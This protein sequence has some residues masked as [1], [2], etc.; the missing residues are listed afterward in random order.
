[1]KKPN[2]STEALQPYIEQIEKLPKVQRLVIC[3]GTIAVIL[4]LFI[5][6]SAWPKYDKINK[7]STEIEKL[8]K[9]LASMKIEAAK[10]P[11]YRKKLEDSKAEFALVKKKLPEEKDIP[12]LLNS[13]S[14]SGKEAGLELLLFQLEKEVQKD[15]YA[16][17]P[18]SIKI[19]GGYHN[20]GQFLSKVA[21]LSRVVNIR[22]LVLRPDKG[23]S[24]LTTS[25]TAVTYRFVDKPAAKK[26]SKKS[27]KR[28]KK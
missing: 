10:L 18:V 15:F 8:D 19:H 27:K 6:L 11:Q 5:Y 13:I 21:S 24:I 28:K 4:G 22:N 12:D 26:A 2:I 14:S 16:E 3:F 20:L 23:S 9:Q 25:C 17:I 7:L 1:M